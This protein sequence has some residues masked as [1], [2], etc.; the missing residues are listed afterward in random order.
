MTILHITRR[1]VATPAPKSNVNTLDLLTTINN[2]ATVSHKQVTCLLRFFSSWSSSNKHSFVI[3][4]ARISLAVLISL[5]RILV[6][7]VA[8]V[9]D[10]LTFATRTNPSWLSMVSTRRLKAN[11]LLNSCHLLLKRHLPHEYFFF[12]GSTFAF[13]KESEC[14]L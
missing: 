12:Q 7:Y 6:E 5:F 13:V 2:K 14:I 9:D 10:V 11:F 3:G 4:R 1:T 8:T